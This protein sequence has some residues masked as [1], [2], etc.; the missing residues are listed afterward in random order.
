MCVDTHASEYHFTCNFC[1]ATVVKTCTQ[2]ILE[3][4]S[5]LKVKV[6]FWTIP[7]VG[8]RVHIGADITDSDV[9]DFREGLNDEERFE[10]ALSDLAW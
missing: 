5:S 2:Q 7:R 9:L 3:A 10:Q 1:D 8:P 6:D 4:L